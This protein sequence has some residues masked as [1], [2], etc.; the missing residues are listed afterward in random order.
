MYLRIATLASVSK[1]EM[2]GLFRASFL[3]F[4]LV[5]TL[6]LWRDCLVPGARAAPRGLGD[7]RCEVPPPEKLRPPSP[8]KKR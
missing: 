5:P 8:L 2:F 3:F 6:L 1:S 4:L 7:R